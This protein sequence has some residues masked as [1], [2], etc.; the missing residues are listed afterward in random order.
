[1]DVRGF[2]RPPSSECD[3]P[4]AG[5]QAANFTVKVMRPSLK[6]ERANI[7]RF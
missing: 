6:P 1:M 5:F 3:G 2:V 7:G 4:P